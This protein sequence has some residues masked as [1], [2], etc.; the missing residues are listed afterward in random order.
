MSPSRFNLFRFL[1]LSLSFFLSLCSSLLEQHYCALTYSTDISR[2]GSIALSMERSPFPPRRPSHLSPT[3]GRERP[4][5]TRTKNGGLH[6]RRD[7]I[8]RLPFLPAHPQ[9]A[10]PHPTTPFPPTRHQPLP[11]PTVSL[12][13]RRPDPRFPYGPSSQ[14]SLTLVRMNA[15]LLQST[16]PAKAEYRGC[17]ELARGRPPDTPSAM[18]VAS[19]TNNGT[20]NR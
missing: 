3:R 12:G 5:T 14:S 13:T 20:R 10:P 8:L 9:P 6:R 1:S 2:R 7:A 19:H 17:L 18:D 11:L 15:W 4:Q 16:Y